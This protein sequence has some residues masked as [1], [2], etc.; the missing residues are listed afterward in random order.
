MMSCSDHSWTISPVPGDLHD[1]VLADAEVHGVAG[2]DGLLLLGGQVQ[3]VAAED[4]DVP[5]GLGCHLVVEADQV[6]LRWESTIRRAAGRTSSGPPHAQ[7]WTRRP[8]RSSSLKPN[9]AKRNKMV[10]SAVM[11]ASPGAQVVAVVPDD[12]ALL[13]EGDEHPRRLAL[14]RRDAPALDVEQRHAGGHAGG[15]AEFSVIGRDPRGQRAGGQLGGGLVDHLAGL[16]EGLD[17]RA[18]RWS[19]PGGPRRGSRGR[20]GPGPCAGPRR[21]GRRPWPSRRSCTGSL[22][23]TVEDPGDRDL[24]RQPGR[25]PR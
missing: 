25:R 9:G 4:D 6:V 21:R 5:V 20:G 19:R 16:V 24:V 3:L 2:A 7:D 8:S 1:E 11:R 22:A 17:R 13:V 23:S 10:P 12:L 15:V 18:R 14:R